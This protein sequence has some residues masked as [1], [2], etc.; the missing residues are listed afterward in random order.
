MKEEIQM[1]P[2]LSNTKYRRR[3][4][5]MRHGEV[6]YFNDDGSPVK[7]PNLVKLTVKGSQQADAMRSLLK[8]IQFDRAVC[9][10]LIRT[11][12]P[13]RRA[14]GDQE[15]EIENIDALKEIQPRSYISV[16]ESLR[17]AELV[18]AFEN[19]NKENSSYGNGELFVDFSKRISEVFN[20]LIAQDDWTS[21][22]IVAHDA[23]NRLLL[24]MVASSG[25]NNNQLMLNNMGGFDQ[26]P[27]CLNIIDVDVIDRE[28]KL[29][30]IK[31]MNITPQNLIKE[32]NH[33]TSMEQIFR[34]YAS[35][36]ITK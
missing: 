12:E 2:P 25:F 7:E 33:L 5:L 24:S 6:N 23:V 14:L 29:A 34:P 13:A 1:Y 35:S 21:L 15:I 32:E 22:L 16:P 18:Y 4:Y 31:A 10:G 30:R 17:E 20:K 26:D 3:I 28:I 8:K 11:Q 36:Y 27:C 9:S 19:A